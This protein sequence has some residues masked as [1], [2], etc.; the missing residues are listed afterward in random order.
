MLPLVVPAQSRNLVADAFHDGGTGTAAGRARARIS[1][2]A[3]SRA[4]W[5]ATGRLN[6][7]TC[8]VCGGVGARTS[9]RST[10]VQNV[11][12]E[13]TGSGWKVQRPR[14]QLRTL[15]GDYPTDPPTPKPAAT[16]DY[17]DVHHAPRTSG[18]NLPR[19]RR[20]HLRLG[21]PRVRRLQWNPR[22]QLLLGDDVPGEN[23]TY[24][25][26]VQRGEPPSPSDLLAAYG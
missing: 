4:S 5:T 6:L 7:L 25:G 15:G 11:L 23:Q 13:F 19:L 9:R 8:A 14:R 20:A 1:P 18:G 2:F 24:R 17:H 26:A 16:F 12:D 21:G 22:D 3:R 10:C